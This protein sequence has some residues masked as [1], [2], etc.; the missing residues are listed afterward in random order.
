MGVRSFVLA[1]GIALLLASGAQAAAGALSY[2]CL[3]RPIEGIAAG[4]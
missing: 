3:G 2:R 4:A 1:A